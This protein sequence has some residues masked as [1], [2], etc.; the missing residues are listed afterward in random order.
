MIYREFKP[1]TLLRPYIETYW[2]ISGFAGK[3]EFYKILPDG[4]VDIIFST[5]EDKQFGLT[6]FIPNIIGTMTTYLNGSYSNHV[7]VIGIRFKPVG[8]TAF[9]RTPL[10]EFTDQRMDLNL[11]ETLFDESFYTELSKKSAVQ[12]QVLYFDSYLICRL[13]H[14]YNVDNQMMYAVNLIQQTNGSISLAKV[15]S[16][17]CLSSRQFERRFKAA[18]GISAKMF[19]KIIKFKHTALY[20]ENNPDLSLFLAAVDCGYYD[21]SHLTKDFKS[22]TGTPPSNFRL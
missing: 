19:S 9:L 8:L 11:A 17:S 6:P 22:L 3:E 7:N 18:T 4:C 5:N 13:A 1:D 2:T 20:L 21:L 12:E 15:S 10:Y 16:K 14:I